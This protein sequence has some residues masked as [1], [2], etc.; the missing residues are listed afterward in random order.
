MA[1]YRHKKNFSKY[2]SKAGIKKKSKYLYILTVFLSFSKKI[3]NKKK[4]KIER[5]K[6]KNL[7]KKRI[8]LE[9]V[10]S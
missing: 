3:K 9:L 8:I 5:F 6:I 2:F 10:H 1:K 7:I 4:R